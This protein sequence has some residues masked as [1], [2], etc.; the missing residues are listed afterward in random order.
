MV[1]VVG[2]SRCPFSISGKRLRHL[3]EQSGQGLD[4]AKLAVRLGALVLIMENVVNLVDEDSLHQVLSN[5]NA[6][7]LLEGFVALC[8]WRLID[9]ELGGHSGRE[10]V[11]PR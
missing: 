6:Y 7:M 2:P 8:V 9:C 4:I 1:V 5:I 10:R 11:F 3:D